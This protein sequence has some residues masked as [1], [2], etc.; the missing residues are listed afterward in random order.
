MDKMDELKEELSDVKDNSRPVIFSAHGVPKSV[1]EE[2]KLKNLLLHNQILSFIF[3]SFF[4][5]LW[6]I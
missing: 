2:A 6:L 1:P 4:K 5:I 3:T